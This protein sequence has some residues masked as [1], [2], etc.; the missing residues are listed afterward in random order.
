MKTEQIREKN[1]VIVNVDTSIYIAT[2]KRNNFGVSDIFD[3]SFKEDRIFGK[4][5]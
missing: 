1:F 5:Y 4:F 3:G 2:F